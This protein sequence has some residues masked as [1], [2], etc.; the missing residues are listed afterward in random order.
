M[1]TERESKKLKKEEE[2]IK[3]R[4]SANYSQ[5][6]FDDLLRLEQKY[7]NYYWKC[8]N[9]L[10]NMEQQQ[11]TQ[12]PHNKDLKKRIE[13]MKDEV[14]KYEKKITKIEELDNKAGRI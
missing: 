2:E 12:A 6:N 3:E 9:A 5:A 1:G 10:R 14:T 11:E 8:K 13:E 4:E 7:E